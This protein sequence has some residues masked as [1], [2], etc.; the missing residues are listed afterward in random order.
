MDVDNMKKQLDKAFE[1]EDLQYCDHEMTA[2][3]GE[4]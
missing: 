2:V 4:E 1:G 3:G